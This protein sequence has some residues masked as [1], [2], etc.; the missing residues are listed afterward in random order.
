[1][2][3]P[4]MSDAEYAA[5]KPYVEEILALYQQQI[6]RN[7]DPKVLEAA[8]RI[9]LMT[10][11]VDVI[12]GFNLLPDQLTDYVNRVCAQLFNDTVTAVRNWDASGP[13]RP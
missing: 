8:W 4:R 2:T 5:Y 11:L 12:R 13:P 9:G 1:M 6:S 7:P 3:E 10:V